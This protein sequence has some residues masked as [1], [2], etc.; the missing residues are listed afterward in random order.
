[1]VGYVRLWKNS[2]GLS[3]CLV[4]GIVE[5]G[6]DFNPP[7]A[8]LVRGFL[9]PQLLVVGYGGQGLNLQIGFLRD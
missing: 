3:A 1:M 5:I 4:K 6:F 2:L 7:P 8:L 9:R